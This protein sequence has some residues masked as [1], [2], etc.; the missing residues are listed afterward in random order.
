MPGMMNQRVWA[1]GD[2]KDMEANLHCICS[3]GEASQTPVWPCPVVSSYWDG[4][5]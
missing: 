5:C 3:T 1:R 2:E 4:Q